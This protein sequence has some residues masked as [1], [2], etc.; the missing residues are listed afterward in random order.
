MSPVPPS[1]RK[2]TDRMVDC[3]R[4]AAEGKSNAA[5]G[6]SLYLSED[7]VKTHMRRAFQV[8]RVD[9][10]T[11]AVLEAQRLGVLENEPRYTGPERRGPTRGRRRGDA[12]NTRPAP[13]RP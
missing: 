11:S 9:N 7:T 13:S 12:R 4:L 10:R 6:R 8:L 3:L 1:R 5:I 2:L